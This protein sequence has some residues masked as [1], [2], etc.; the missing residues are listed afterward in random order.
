MSLI[1]VT[2]L[3]ILCCGCAEANAPPQNHLPMRDSLGIEIVEA[4][5]LSNLDTLAWRV[6]STKSLTI[7]VTDG[8]AP[9]VFAA[10]AGV[11]RLRDGRIV[12]ADRGVDVLRFFDETGSF[13]YAV[14]GRGDGPSEYRSIHLLRKMASDSLIIVDQE[15]ARIT[16]LDPEG[17]QA[18]RYRMATSA[19]EVLPI[20]AWGVFADGTQLTM[21]FEGM[22]EVAP[23]VRQYRSGFRRLSQGGQVV[24]SYEGAIQSMR[25][26]NRAIAGPDAGSGGPPPAEWAVGETLFLYAPNPAELEWWIYGDLEGV[27]RILRIGDSDPWAVAADENLFGLF[28]ADRSEALWFELSASQGENGEALWVVHPPGQRPLIGLRLPVVG[29]LHPGA[30]TPIMEIG[31]DYLL[32][33]SLNEDGAP[34][35]R[36]MSL[37]KGSIGTR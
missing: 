31:E 29:A 13:L 36:M 23:G 19:G 25:M 20:P 8:E 14:G 22:D 17:Q 12:V 6:D 3:S 24:A 27:E 26:V 37:Q 21:T 9:Y 11:A 18:R 2:A 35:V 5:D 4:A 32:L 7:G 34:V 28:T 10:I 16:V 1:R 33:A 15:G 30:R